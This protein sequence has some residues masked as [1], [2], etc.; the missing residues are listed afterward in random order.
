MKDF[1]IPSASGQGGHVQHTADFFSATGDV[2]TSIFFPRLSIVGSQSDQCGDLMAIESAQFGQMRQE[3]G[4]GLRAD[5]GCALEQ[6]I[7]VLQI[8]VGLDVVVDEFVKFPDLLFERFDHFADTLT[9][10]DMVDH[11][12]AVGFL[13]EQVMELSPSCNQFG[14]GLNMGCFRLFWL[15]FD[16]FAESG[17][18]AGVDGIGLGEFAETSCEVSHLSRIG[19]D[20]IVA[21]LKEFDGE[22]FFVTASCFHDNLC[23]TE[24][25]Q[26][27]NE[28]PV[29]LSCVEI[30]AVELDG[31]GCDLKRFF[32]DVDADEKCSGHGVLPFLPMRAWQRRWLLA[33]AA[34]RVR[35][36][37]TARTTLRDGLE[38]LNTTGL[39]PPLAAASARYARLVSSQNCTYGTTTNHAFCQHTSSRRARR[40]L[41]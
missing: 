11:S 35:S 8:I 30:T 19:D 40:E 41:I 14:E 1:W 38:D 16:N 22:R 21:G 6:S 29:A 12:I 28:F 4:A 33:Q 13:G 24:V 15:G 2:G 31:L 36:I 23:Y 37:A 25:M 39:T 26:A 10:L 5:A 20:H 3:H 32:G 18:D 7:F 9:D 17:D 27:V 34:V